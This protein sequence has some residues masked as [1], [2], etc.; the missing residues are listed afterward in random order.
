[1]GAFFFEVFIHSYHFNNK[2]CQ[3]GE[4]DKNHKAC[5]EKNHN[6]SKWV[7]YGIRTYQKVYTKNCKK[8]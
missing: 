8:N 2:T 4:T 6:K 3:E 1:M 5:R 7:I